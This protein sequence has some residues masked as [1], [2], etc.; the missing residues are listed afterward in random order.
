MGLRTLPFTHTHK[1]TSEATAGLSEGKRN[2]QF[3][4]GIQ[5]A[6]GMR[7]SASEQGQ[8]EIAALICLSGDRRRYL[9]SAAW[10]VLAFQLGHRPKICGNA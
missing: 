9:K 2:S 8:R 5:S 4:F 1:H 3:D 10:R 7:E 6:T